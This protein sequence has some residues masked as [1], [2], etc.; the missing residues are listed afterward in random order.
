MSQQPEPDAAK[1]AN[2]TAVDIL[3]ELKED[4]KPIVKPPSWGRKTV[5][6]YY[7]IKFALEVKQ[8]IDAMLADGEDRV[9]YYE[10]FSKQPFKFSPDTLYNYVYQAIKYL[11]E[12]DIKDVDR[13]YYIKVTDRIMTNR[14]KG[15]GVRLSFHTDVP[16]AYVDIAP[17]K[18]SK[19][20]EN[21][22]I[23]KK[24]DE[25]LETAAVGDIFE[26]NNIGLTEME[27]TEIN[28]MLAGTESF[29]T[30]DITQTKIKILKEK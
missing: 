20:V 2:N 23:R 22:G 19:K 12:Q 11:K 18:I 14:E 16:A 25:W 1:P 30:A 26:A 13:A 28:N 29:L 7:R 15:V 9:Y 24:I 8:V 6:P 27:L 3:R 5:S 4:I 10:K 21:S 17:D